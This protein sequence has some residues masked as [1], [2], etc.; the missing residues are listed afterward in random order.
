MSSKITTTIAARVPHGVKA[1]I[2]NAL[3]MGN[4]SI[5]DIVIDL[6]DKLHSG[7]LEVMDGKII[8][9]EPVSEG[10][11]LNMSDFLDACE[12]KGIRPQDALNKAA[13]MI[14]RS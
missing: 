3:K 14:W 1:M 12:G 11:E 6:A 5:K 13:Q 9:P 8:I 4:S 7:E 2:E 10:S